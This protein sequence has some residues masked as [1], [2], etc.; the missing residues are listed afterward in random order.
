M[1]FN[2]FNLSGF[3]KTISARFFLSDADVRLNSSPDTFG[4][5]PI[6]NATILDAK[7]GVNF[8]FDAN[9]PDNKQKSKF[10]NGQVVLTQVLSSQIVFQGYYSGL[11]TSRNN[12]NGILGAGFQSASTSIFDGTISTAN[13]HLNYTPNQAQKADVKTAL[14]NCIGFGSKN[15]ALILEKVN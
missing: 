13:G 9:D 3:E 11:K 10:F 1:L 12:D 14:C 8:V 15:S 6:S 2:I 4:V 7:Q 5:S